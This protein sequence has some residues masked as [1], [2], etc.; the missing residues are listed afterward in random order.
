MP[1]PQAWC[2]MRM[3]ALLIV[4]LPVADSGSELYFLKLIVMMPQETLGTLVF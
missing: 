3:L 4:K 2:T 1:T